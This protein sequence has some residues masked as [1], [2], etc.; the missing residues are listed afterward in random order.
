MDFYTKI[1]SSILQPVHNTTCTMCLVLQNV[2]VDSD[3]VSLLEEIK[4]SRQLD[5]V[6]GIELRH[7]E[8]PKSE[9][10][11]VIDTDDPVTILFEYMKQR[12]LRLIDLLH[13][14][15]KDHSDT[16]SRDEFQQGLKVCIHVRPT[17]K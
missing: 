11:L 15:D 3:F 1:F 2:C 13:N 12:N 4:E 8:L 7:D 14:L 10:S 5:V 17:H 9:R 6:Y 16:V